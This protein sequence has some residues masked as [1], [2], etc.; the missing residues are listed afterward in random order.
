MKRIFIIIL[1]LSFSFMLFAQDKPKDTKTISKE[2]ISDKTY[3]ETLLEDFETNTYNKKNLIF[4]YTRWQKA[5]LSIR[6]EYPAPSKKSKKYLGMKIFGKQGDVFTIKMAKPL[7]INNYC[8]EISIWVYGKRFTGQLSI[9]LAD[10][11]NNYHRII[12]GKLDFLGWRKLTVKLDRRVTQQ[13]D[14]LN[15]KRKIKITKLQYRPGNSRLRRPKW[16][17]FY[18]DNITA[19]VREK[20]TDR[21]SDDW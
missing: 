1:S 12:L 20:Y 16:Q 19:K 8:K 14:F 13:D 4:R 7:I 11:N 2:K 10:A 21:Q 3:H 17:Y 6:D 15:Q 5:S 18:V 9:I